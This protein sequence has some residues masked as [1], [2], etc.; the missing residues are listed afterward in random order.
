MLK[1]FWLQGLI[2]A[3]STVVAL[4]MWG[5]DA[6]PVLYGGLVAMANTGLLVWRW[7]KGLYDYHCDG[8]RHLR[9]FRRSLKERFFVVGIL[10]AAGYFYG[11]L[12][13]GFQ[14]LP[15]L[16]GFVVGQLAWGIAL[17]S[18]TED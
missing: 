16:V 17:G 10:L 18:R 9:S 13:P 2:V 1:A 5:L 15:M 4:S 12:E 3:V 6:W 7:R 11:W 14:T 8:P